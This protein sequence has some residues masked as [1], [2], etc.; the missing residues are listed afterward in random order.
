VLQH[1][2]FATFCFLRTALRA[3]LKKQNILFDTLGGIRTLWFSHP[4]VQPWTPFHARIH[5]VLRDRHLTQ[6]QQR[7]LVAVSGGQDSLCLMQL[8]LDLQSKWQWQL[9]I[10]H[11]NHRWR[12]D[13]DANAVHVRNLA[14]AW[15]VPY[16]EAIAPEDL[17]KTEDAARNWR[18]GALAELAQVHQFE[19]VVTGHTAS[20]RA[21]TLLYNL[22]R[23]SGSDGLQALSWQRPLTEK[24]TEKLTEQCD[25]IRPLSLIRPL[26]E[27]TRAETAEFCQ[28]RNLPIWFDST[29]Q[30]VSYTRNRIRQELMPY[31]RSHFNPQVE[32]TLAQT[33]ELLRAERV[34]WEQM[35]QAWMEQVVESE[36]ER[37]AAPRLN[38]KRL[39]AAGLAIQRRVIRRWIKDVLNIGLTFEQVEK[40]VRLI[41]APNRSQTDPLPG[42]AIVCV[43]G[44]WVGVV[45]A[46]G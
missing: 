34:E 32:Q 41:D 1:L 6:P 38:R 22:L 20:D 7:L 15:A 11:C 28:A 5:Q 21:E 33:A 36:M 18:Y 9:A 8:L 12:T 26:L 3:V 14:I 40:I 43:S 16:F 27:V 25:L 4:M 2:N 42:G 37:D 23:G 46:E 19:T 45:L 39:Q 13:A 44:E 10:A 24:L 31:L 29:N 30:D 17:A 35:E